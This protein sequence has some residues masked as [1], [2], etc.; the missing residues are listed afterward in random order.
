MSLRKL[1]REKLKRDKESKYLNE[2]KDKSFYKNSENY[3]EVRV[4]KKF[5]KNNYRE[6]NG[7]KHV[8]CKN[9]KCMIHEDKYNP[10]DNPIKHLIYDLNLIKKA[11][12]FIFMVIFFKK[13]RKR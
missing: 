8:V 7:N 12:I 5:W 1:F 9:G 11:I 2:T 6:L 3:K 4:A 10:L 13:K